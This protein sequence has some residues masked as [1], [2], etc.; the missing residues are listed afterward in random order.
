MPSYPQFV[1]HS[2]IPIVGCGGIGCVVGAEAQVEEASG[3]W[4]KT[5]FYRE[6]NFL[7]ATVYSVASGNPKVVELRVDLRPIARAVMRAHS[8][9]H[10]SDLAKSDVTE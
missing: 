9:F 7:C 10:A 8:T 6:G 2:G 4:V 1:T 3:V 5:R